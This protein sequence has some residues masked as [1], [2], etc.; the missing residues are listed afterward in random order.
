L[1]LV[2]AASPAGAE[3]MAERDV[4]EPLRPWIGWV[5]R[6]HE[7]ALCPVQNGAVEEAR[8]CAWPSR[9]ALEVDDAGGRFTQEW[10]VFREAWVPLPG[11][12]KRW[13]QAVVVGE[14]AAPVV[15]REGAPYVRLAP[16]V[17]RVAG[18]FVWSTLP[19]LLPV[20]REVGLLQ[21]RVRGAPVAA[22]SR[23]TDGRLWLAARGP[24]AEEPSRL[25][26][27]TSRLVVDDAP[28]RVE[29][30][31]ELDVAGASREVRL[32]PGVLAGFVPLSVESSLPVRVEPDGDLVVQVRPGRWVVT[33]VARLDGP[34]SALALPPAAEAALG[35]HGVRD[36]TE[37]WA[38][39][40]H[41]DL[42][43]VSVEG[44][45]AVDPTQTRIPPEWRAHPTFAVAPG[46]TMQLVEK[47]RGDA[48]PAPDRLALQRTLWLDFDGGGWTVRDDVTGRLSRSWRLEMGPETTL[49]R[50]AVAGEDQ[51]V[52]RL[53]GAEGAGVELRQGE[54]ALEADSRVENARARIPAVGW[55]QDFAEV[56][57]V[58]QIPP[59]WRLFHASGVDRAEPTWVTGWSLLDLFLVLVAALAV[60]RLF[61]AL[62]G[63]GAL[64]ALVLAWTEPG[65]PQW[66]WLAVLA[67]E[68]LVRVLPVGRART[69]LRAVRLVALAV[70]ALVLVPF[71]VTQVRAAMHPALEAPGRGALLEVPRPMAAP[72]APP[73]EADVA[74]EEYVL[75]K[76]GALS[77]ES[78]PPAA[79]APAPRR[80]YAPDPNAR[81]TTGPGLPTWT[82]H[83]VL[84]TWRGPVDAG[85]ML[86]LW[87]VPPG[88]T[89]ALA[90][91][92]VALLAL[93]G[94]CLLRGLREPLVA[95]GDGA[96][97]SPVSAASALLALLALAGGATLP[98]DARAEFPPPALLDELRGR[99][100][101]APSCAPVCAAAP[102][103]ALEIG[104][105][106]LRLR[107]ELDAGA[108]V[109]AP[110]PGDAARFSPEQVTV[111]GEPAS[112]L[113]RDAGG[114]LWLAAEPGRHRVEMTGRIADRDAVEI[115]LPLRPHRIDVGASVAAAGWR[116]EG[117][118]ESGAPDATLRL[119]REH[120]LG[121]ASRD[122]GNGAPALLPPFARVVRHVSLGLRFDVTT[123]VERVS[124][125]GAP[126]V[127]AVPLLPGESVTTEGVRVADGRALVTLAPGAAALQWS[128][129]LEPA[130]SLVLRAPDA[131]PWSETWTLDV[132][133][134]WHVETE[135]IPVVHAGEGAA[136]ATPRVRTWR[137]WPGEEVR[138]SLVRPEGVEGATLTIDRTSLTVTPGLRA[139]DVALEIAL[140]SSRGG[141]HTLLLPEGA[142]LQSVSLNGGLQPVRQEGRSVTLPLRPGTQEA[143]LVWR[144]GVPLAARLET[145]AVDAGA[146]SV[147]ASLAIEMPADRWTLLLGGPRLGPVVLF[148]SFLAVVA[149]LAFGLGRV[150]TTPLRARHWFLLGVGMTQAPIWASAIVVGWLLALGWRRAHGAALS[151]PLFRIVQIALA[152]ATV[153][154]LVSLFAAIEQGLLG[155]P[156]MQIR[157]S[158]SD[159]EHLRWYQDR[160]GSVLPSAWVLS[161]PLWVYRAAMLAWALWIASALLGWLRWGWASFSDGGAWRAFPPRKSVSA[162]RSART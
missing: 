66:S 33:L 74:T 151:N 9:L 111:D 53:P 63:A 94:V 78:A 10:R 65:A 73:E 162:D 97:P 156:E 139:R 157:G 134:V 71:L 4:P 14:A 147:N 60:G 30:R 137:P 80:A 158:G 161:A 25:D 133:P 21:L 51:V 110:L 154:A 44:V 58:A 20:P 117:V 108:R 136:H 132:S 159:A 15:A 3:P 41:T 57:A 96:P 86:R 17:H 93:L 100:L 24:G 6:G 69:A 118:G 23:D 82:W 70:L 12:A 22:P 1:L 128:S 16:G 72:A 119:V 61:G 105:D 106:A 138:L 32:D 52:T 91:L 47:R 120:A 85:Q 95:P 143:A 13:P 107:L 67:A 146:P 46:D 89:F 49:G 142:E 130:A 42:R 141:Q 59:G 131:V 5:L 11:D 35:E 90:L 77:Y 7:D 48:D 81:V 122:A 152:L 19:A 113:R 103:L 104:D 125:L 54:L 160:S 101:E 37:T 112:G 148:W 50:V 76:R 116:V 153:A 115:S 79:Q 98:R 92:R 18:A 64:A 29:S 75:H 124:P 34:V 127:L 84:L 55:R 109:A 39:E 145:P 38:F 68:A 62:W 31:F 8:P 102:R 88:G 28:L 27:E 121:A 99:L 83:E 140:R 26:L 149:L 56:A 126:I 129:V 123:R 144:E 36:A 2:L 114:V 155:L 40:A 87:L 43:L 150:R 45:P 135:G